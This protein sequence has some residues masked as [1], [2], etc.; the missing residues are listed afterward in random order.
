[1]AHRAD[2]PELFDIEMDELARMLAFITP[3]RFGR[4]QGTELVQSQTAENTA[5]RGRWHAG[6]G[7]DL[8]ARPALPTQPLDLFGHRL[9]CR[10]AQPMGPRWSVLQACQPFTAIS[11]NP[12]P[13]GPRADACGFGNGFRRLPALHLPYNPLS[14][15]RR[16]PGILSTFIRFSLGIWS[17]NNVSFLGQ[18]RLD[19][20][21]KADS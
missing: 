16:Q 11:I 8:L 14:I 13:N 9:G 10:P 15:A 17:F 18:N 12:L 3:D 7:G 6:R 19:N 21:L 1:V 5:D 4:L 2:P 20:L